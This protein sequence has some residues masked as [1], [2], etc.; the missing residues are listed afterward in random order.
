MAA[1][2]TSM[3]LA[4][5]ASTSAS[6]KVGFYKSTCPSA[7]A[8]VSK[9]VNKAISAN[10]GIAAGLIRLH[11]HDCFVRGCDG[12]VLIESKPGNTAERD[13]PA[14]NPSLR[15]FEVIEEA[16]A[17]IEAVC[18]QTVSCADIV[19]FAARDS[20]YKAGRINYDVPA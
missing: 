13:H 7:E 17:E 6:L 19:A 3:A 9:A 20:A 5:V 16:T 12:S 14:N 11:F 4:E 1:S 2:C 18:P 10:P 15:G 8:I